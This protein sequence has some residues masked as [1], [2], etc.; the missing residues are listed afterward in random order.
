V[1]NA[2]I[3]PAGINGGINVFATDPVQ[4]MVDVNGYFDSTP[5]STAYAFYPLVPCRVA[6]TRRDPGMFG[7]PQM[8]GG[9]SR[10]FPIGLSSCLPVDALPKSY[11][12]NVTV[13]PAQPLGYLALWPATTAQ[14]L[15][16]STLNAPFGDVIASAAIVHAGGGNAAASVFAS[17][18]TDVVLDINGYFSVPGRSGAL[19]F[20]PLPPCRVVDTRRTTGPLGGPILPRNTSRGFQI[21]ASGDCNVPSSA[22]AYSLN[23]TVVPSGYL[24]Y[25]TISPAGQPQ[26]SVSTLNSSDGRFVANAAIVPAGLNG[27][28]TVFVTDESHVVLDINGYFSAPQ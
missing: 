14:P 27:A 8:P 26:P 3:V 15:R 7:G 24:G 28:L 2:A 11:S 21:P 20:N 4:L 23:V 17:D 22:S 9:A 18:R 16:I 19:L 12:L 10:D 6:D 5:S 25:V 13:V 1:S